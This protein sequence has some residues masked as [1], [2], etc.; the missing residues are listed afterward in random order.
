[1]T[2]RNGAPAE[3]QGDLFDLL[4]PQ[5]PNEPAQKFQPAPVD[6][7]EVELADLR[8]R[9]T[10]ALKQV[11]KGKMAASSGERTIRSAFAAARQKD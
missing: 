9:L 4:V 2:T 10:T 7:D 8:D 11:R 6:N 3:G 1:M 5:A